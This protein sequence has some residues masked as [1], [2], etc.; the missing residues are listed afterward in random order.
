[1]NFADIIRSFTGGQS[2]ESASPVQALLPSILQMVG[3]GGGL[4]SLVRAF[5]QNGMGDIARSWV[6]TGP[7]QSVSPEQ[8]QTA[9][10]SDTIAKMA[11][12]SGLSNDAVTSHLSQILPRLVDRLTPN[13]HTGD[14][15][16]VQS[17]GQELLSSLMTRKSG[18]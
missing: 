15:V 4:D 16:D 2:S 3:Q 1:M 10:G 14:A 13:G 9:L 17:I 12:E 5:E 8:V 7:N 18:A 11:D 6:G